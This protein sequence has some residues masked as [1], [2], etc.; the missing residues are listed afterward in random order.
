MDPH[1]KYLRLSH[2]CLYWVK[3]TIEMRYAGLEEIQRTLR[4]REMQLQ[5]AASRSSGNQAERTDSGR[6]AGLNITTGSSSSSRQDARSAS[7]IQQHHTAG[8]SR[9][10]WTSANAIAARNAPGHITLFR[11]QDQGRIAGLFD[12]SGRLERIETLL[13][14]P[15]SDFSATRSLFYFSTD[16]RVAEYY[17][18]YAKRRANCESVVIICLSIPNAAIESLS[19]PDVQRIY[20]PDDEWKEL[21]WRCRTDKPLPPH[22]RKYQQAMLAIGTI[23]RGPERVYRA[24]SSWQQVTESCLLKVGPSHDS[25]PCVHFVDREK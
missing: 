21:I 9:D 7:G 4:E 5:R 17:A 18:A 15:P 11:A 24:M 13:S 6:H 23:S 20:W 16:S 1:F 25:G 2:S 12:D 19:E 10:F 14:S 3:D 22:L 8:I